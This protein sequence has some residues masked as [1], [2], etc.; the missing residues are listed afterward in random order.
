MDH[1]FE[2]HIKHVF[3]NAMNAAQ[4]AALCSHM[5]DSRAD[6]EPVRGHADIVVINASERLLDALGTYTKVAEVKSGLW[7]LGDFTRRLVD[8]S[9]F[10]K[11]AAVDAALIILSEGIN[12]TDGHFRA[13]SWIE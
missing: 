1:H 5:D 10:V 11:E 13:P 2:Q 9:L 7:V 8:C 4:M 6:T 3:E 12:E